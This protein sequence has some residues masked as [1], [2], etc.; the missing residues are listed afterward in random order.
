LQIITEQDFPTYVKNTSAWKFLISCSTIHAGSSV[1]LL[2]HIGFIDEWPPAGGSQQIR[3]KSD[4]LIEDLEIQLGA[5]QVAFAKIKVS[6]AHSAFP[7][8]DPTESESGVSA[9]RSRIETVAT[10]EI[11][12]HNALSPWSPR[13]APGPNPLFP[14]IKKH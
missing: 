3:Q 13:P 12:R 14:L 5:S 4:E 11:K 1:L 2:A 10:A 9:M 8:R 7:E 6:F